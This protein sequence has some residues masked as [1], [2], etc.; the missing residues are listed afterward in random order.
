[1][2]LKLFRCVGGE[3]VIPH[4]DLV[5]ISRSDGGNLVV[6]P[7]REVWERSELNAVELANWSF[8]VA[9]TGKAML[10]SLPQ[11]KDGCINY[12]EAGNWALNEVA[13]PAGIFKSAKAY[14]KVHLHLLGRNPN[15]TNP[16]LSWGEAPNF[17]KF[18]DRFIWAENNERLTAKECL[19]II[20]RAEEILVEI[21]GMQQ[22]QI[23]RWTI[24]VLCGYPTAELNCPDCN[25][26]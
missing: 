13:A 24:C 25:Q 4:K 26:N 5:L 16:D 14:R 12:W 20:K 7:P 2:S 19:M 10:E 17:P 21:Y 8:L 18:S 1:M 9:A 23:D 6:N 11:L 15:S 22:S 3:I